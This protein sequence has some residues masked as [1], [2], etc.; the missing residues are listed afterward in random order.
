[1]ITSVL[2]YFLHAILCP[3]HTIPLKTI[4]D[5][6]FRNIVIKDGLFWL[7]IV[8]LPRLI[9][10]SSEHEVLILWR[11]IRRLFLHAQIGAKSIFISE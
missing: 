9:V 7:S 11:R 3:E 2:F 1:M 10:T 8:M 4:T 6:S 5:R